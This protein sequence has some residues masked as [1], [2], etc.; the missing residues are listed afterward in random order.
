MLSPTTLRSWPGEARATI[1]LALPLIGGQLT[2][3]GMGVAD[4]LL[5]GHLNAHVLGT[6]AVATALY[7]IANMAAVGVNAAL[8]PSVAQL[9]GAGRRNLAGPLFRQALM[10]ATMLGL[11]LMSAV[12]YIGPSLAVWLGFEAGLA[13]DMGDF[14]RTIAPATPAVS[15]FYCCR[16]LSEGLSMPR[17]TMLIGLFGLCVLVPT[18]YILMYA[19]FGNE[20]LG[21]RGCALATVVA[22][23]AQLAVFLLWLRFSGRYQGLGWRDRTRGLDWRLIW[24]L[25]RV[26]LPMAV[27]LL[28][29]TSLFSAAG[30]AIGHF[31]ETAAASHQVALNVAAF[32][33][34]VPLGISITTSVRVGNAAGRG[35]P[36]G[37][38]R[39]GFTGMGLALAVQMVSGGLMLLFPAEIAGL[40]THDSA[41]I[42][43]GVLLL[44]IAGVFQ[45]S[46]GLQVSAM[47]ALRGLKDTK[48]PMVITALAYWVVGFPLALVLAFGMDWHAPG[49]WCGLI[50]GLTVAAGLLTYRFHILS[51]PAA[52]VPPR[53]RLRD[54]MLTPVAKARTAARPHEPG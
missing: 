28:L 6:V 5:A 47:G 9:D 16:G 11:F 52:P 38:R 41:V 37:V 32:S 13:A 53:A 31:G 17:P 26:G 48:V 19:P 36:L 39:A 34:M 42:A 40:Y 14:L 49:M 18:G 25:L 30:L 20:P 4:V 35:D 23:W 29:E 10:I 7:N 3:M 43:G 46:D 45:L 54:R 44:Q 8:A 12:Y 27:S 51:R 22:C 15:L 24:A 33:F 50:A 1:W 21:A 2:S